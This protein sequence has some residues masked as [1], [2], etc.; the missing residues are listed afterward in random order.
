MSKRDITL[1]SVTVALILALVAGIIWDLNGFVLKRTLDTPLTEEM[2]IETMHKYGIMFY[3]KAYEAK[4]R[5]D[6]SYAE[7][8]LN[9][10]ANTLQIIPEVKTYED[11]MTYSESAFQREILRPAPLNGTEVAI[12]KSVSTNGDYVTYMMDIESDTEAYIYIYFA[13]G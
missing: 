9:Y 2:E 11:Y 6:P 12:I 5:I 3:R 13:R 10:I 8:A 7:L 1:I 4:I